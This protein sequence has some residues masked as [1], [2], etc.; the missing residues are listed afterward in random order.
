[1]AWDKYLKFRCNLTDQDKHIYLHYQLFVLCRISFSLP[2]PWQEHAGCPCASAPSV[3]GLW[4]DSCC[5]SGDLSPRQHHSG[6]AAVHTN[7]GSGDLV[8]G[9]KSECGFMSRCLCLQIYS[10]SQCFLL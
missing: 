6:A 9:G 8:L 5:L 3:R 1:M 4:R 10:Y 2:P 7:G